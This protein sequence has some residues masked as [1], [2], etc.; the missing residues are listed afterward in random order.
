MQFVALYRIRALIRRVVRS[1][2]PRTATGLVAPATDVQGRIISG[3][4]PFLK[5]RA[6]ERQA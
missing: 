1:L 4:G 6:I 3:V 2:R 5:R